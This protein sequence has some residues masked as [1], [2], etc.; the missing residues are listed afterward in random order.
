MPI[1]LQPTINPQIMAILA[2]LKHRFRELYAYRLMQ[3]VLYGSQARGDAEFGS[4]INVLV[5]LSG[6]VQPCEEID[7]S[8]D[9]VAD[10]YLQNNEV[11]SCFFID[12]YQVLNSHSSLLRNIH[13]EGI[14]L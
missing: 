7:R 13:K 9:L 6:P 1:A 12:E 10:L 4:D 5:V 2:E 11:I 8:L 3:M 14:T